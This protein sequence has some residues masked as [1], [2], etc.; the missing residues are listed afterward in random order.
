MCTKNQMN[1]SPWFPLLSYHL[2]S[3]KLTFILS[4]MCQLFL[5]GRYWRFSQISLHTQKQRT[6]QKKILTCSTLRCNTVPHNKT[7][8]ELQDKT[9]MCLSFWAL[10]FTNK[11]P[12]KK[13]QTKHFDAQAWIP[14]WKQK[15][16][17][18][19]SN[20]VRIPNLSSNTLPKHT[21]WNCASLL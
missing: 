21:L 5:A 12:N 10:L 20:L 2:A 19:P 4:T 3:L 9:C 13:I 17:Y 14:H 8:K 16:T 7:E 6:R 11:A 1:L 15:Q 18:I